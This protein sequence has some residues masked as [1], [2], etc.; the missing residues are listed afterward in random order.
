MYFTKR[1]NNPNVDLYFIDAISSNDN[2]AEKET[3]HFNFVHVLICSIKLQCFDCFLAPEQKDEK[4][5]SAERRFHGCHCQW[6]WM[7][8]WIN[9]G[10]QGDGW[11][12]R[13]TCWK[14]FCNFKLYLLP[15]FHRSI[16][17]DGAWRTWFM[18]NVLL[19]IFQI[20]R[21]NLITGVYCLPVTWRGTLLLCTHE[22]IVVDKVAGQ[23]QSA[24]VGRC[25]AN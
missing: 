12:W 6:Q 10:G 11:V 21:I 15:V 3:K 13:C 5:A 18:G 23:F 8:G 22:S 1:K 19:Y 17:N 9:T 14:M 25:S 16:L 7:D 2:W 4:N 24:D 20:F